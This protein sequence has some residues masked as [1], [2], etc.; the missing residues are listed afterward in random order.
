L[1]WGGGCG[2]LVRR[3]QRR[4]NRR[5]RLPWQ[6]DVEPNGQACLPLHRV[7]YTVITYEAAAEGRSGRV[8]ARGAVPDGDLSRY[9]AAS[10]F[11][12]EEDRDR[13]AVLRSILSWPNVVVVTH[14]SLEPSD[15]IQAFFR[16]QVD[17]ASEKVFACAV[18]SKARLEKMLEETSV[19]VEGHSLQV[20]A[21]RRITDAGIR[22]ALEAWTERN[23][24]DLPLPRFS[25]DP[26]RGDLGPTRGRAL[27]LLRLTPRVRRGEPSKSI[28][29]E[30]TAEF[31]PGADLTDDSPRE[32]A[33]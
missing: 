15:V 30:F 2:D 26:W 21:T 7:R 16:C 24:P 6:A 18:V 27:D 8:F 14:R 29:R 10:Y 20:A 17:G 32:S 13:D 25:L 5:P 23:Y 33:A 11:N 19:V 28:S 1:G 22:A 3:V 12:D 31:L 4:A 9:F